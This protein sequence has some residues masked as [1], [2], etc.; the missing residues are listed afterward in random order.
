[1]RLPGLAGAI[2][3]LTEAL[4]PAVLG[5]ER[6]SSRRHRVGIAK[7]PVPTLN[8]H[9]PAAQIGDDLLCDAGD[10][11][12]SDRLEKALPPPRACPLV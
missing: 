3:L 8:P 7:L 4:M 5:W 11:L 2:P 12:T 9:F 1:M 6:V 10:W